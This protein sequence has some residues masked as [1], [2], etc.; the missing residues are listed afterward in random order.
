MARPMFLFCS[1]NDAT[2]AQRRSIALVQRSARA[3]PSRSGPFLCL[4]RNHGAHW[5][6]V[7]QPYD[8][9]VA[10]TVRIGQN[11][12][13][14]AGGPPTYLCRIDWLAHD[15]GDRRHKPRSLPGT[16][17]ERSIRATVGVAGAARKSRR[18]RK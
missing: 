12:S 5:E 4:R 6:F 10:R 14:H 17:R 18:S 2:T 8:I 7:A 11:P 1:G 13:G 9:R 16:A 3:S 15:D